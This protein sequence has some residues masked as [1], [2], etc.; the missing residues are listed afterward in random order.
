MSSIELDQNTLKISKEDFNGKN[1]VEVDIRNVEEV[2][3]GSLSN[4]KILGYIIKSIIYAIILIGFGYFLD[5]SQIVGDVSFQ[6]ANTDG[7][8]VGGMLSMGQSMMNFV[9]KMDQ[10][11]LMLGCIA[12]LITCVLSGIWWLKRVPTTE[13]V[14]AGGDNI[15]LPRDEFEKVQN[16][17]RNY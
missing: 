15:H 17:S 14:V 13:I 1:Y 5:F 6:S 7:V 2:R 11:L 9:S 10:Y 16:G 3:K 12:V 4:D 8:P